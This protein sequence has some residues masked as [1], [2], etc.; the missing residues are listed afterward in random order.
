MILCLKQ[1]GLPI[2]WK[3]RIYN[4]VSVPMIVYGMESAAPASQDLHRIEAFRAQSLRKMHRT[5][6]T[7]YT[8]IIAPDV[9]TITNQQ[10]REQTSQPPL[11]HYIHRAQLKLFGHISRAS[12]QCLE[13]NYCFTNAFVYRDGI[14]G[15][16]LR[17]GRPKA[18]WAEQC[19]AQACRWVR[20]LPNPPFSRLDTPDFLL[21]L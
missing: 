6:S 5:P 16:G 20:E 14:A 21:H 12:E 13:R 4:A 10:L 1:S 2:H 8:K 7:Y 9:P 11:T 15:E 18:H 17:R 3:L 19:A